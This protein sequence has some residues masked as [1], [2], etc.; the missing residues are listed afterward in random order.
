MPTLSTHT[1]DP[2]PT[3]GAA[4]GVPGPG[5]GVVVVPADVVSTYAP[6]SPGR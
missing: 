4:G 3:P 2:D 1:R 5:C 6:V